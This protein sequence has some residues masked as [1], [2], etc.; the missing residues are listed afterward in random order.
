MILL[1][2]KSALQRKL[3]LT[4]LLLHFPVHWCNDIF[5]LFWYIDALVY[6]CF[7]IMM[8]WHIFVLIY[9]SIDI[10]IYWYI[11]SCSRLQIADSCHSNFAMALVKSK[12]SSLSC[13]FLKPTTNLFT[14]LSFQY[15]R[16][17]PYQ[18]LHMQEH[19]WMQAL[20]LIYMFLC[21]F[22]GIGDEIE[23]TFRTRCILRSGHFL[24]YNQCH[25]NVTQCYS[26]RTLQ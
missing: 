19:G 8:H 15:S 16:I 6:P 3:S 2:W 7:H 23:N 21:I 9:W 17:F 12:T 10:L 4:S 14:K 24:E 20:W 5:I 13:V 1:K 22:D 18:M 11:Y 26:V 25:A